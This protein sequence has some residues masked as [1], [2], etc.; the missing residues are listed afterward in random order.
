MATDDTG[1][2]G[3]K[4][5]PEPA[6]GTH[7]ISAEE[8]REIRAEIE[9]AF[10]A[11]SGAEAEAGSPLRAKLPARRGLALP[12]GLNLGAVVVTVVALFVL[13][14]LFEREEQALATVASGVLGG[15]AQ[16]LEQFRA[17]AEAELTARDREIEQIRRELDRLAA[18]ADSAVEPDAAALR[19]MAELEDE[20]QTMIAER[21]AV[22]LDGEALARLEELE[23]LQRREELLE[24]QLAAA[25][26]QIEELERVVS[27]A[28]EESQAAAELARLE[29][30]TGELQATIEAR[31]AELEASEDE[32]DQILAER[33]EL[34]SELDRLRTDRSRLQASLARA[35]REIAT[36]RDEA[37]SRATL[38][39]HLNAVSQELAAHPGATGPDREEL[40]NAVESKVEVLTLL[41]SEPLRSRRPGLDRELERYHDALA[42]QHEREGRAAGLRQAADLVARVAA[43]DDELALNE[44]DYGALERTELAELLE[45]L[46]TLL[47]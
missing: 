18:E 33:E 30:E 25:L 43:A 15:E 24:M 19:R 42:E 17:E 35:Q 8:Q 3:G 44:E 39:E 27:R 36:L 46:A 23:R 26:S 9:Q 32:R 13:F 4:T 10:A 47:R 6:T 22:A 1:A 12:V 29:A 21:D 2:S 20:L 31:E 28:E 5:P 16:L 34:S 45:R 40:L 11:A 7:G 37:D 38:R 14:T 41:T